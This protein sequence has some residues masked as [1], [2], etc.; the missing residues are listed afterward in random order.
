[1]LFEELAR[2][3]VSV[4]SEMLGGRTINIMD[5]RGII[6]ASS[7]PERVG[8]FHKGALEAAQTGKA[9]LIRKDQV[10]MYT[11]AKEGCNMPLRVDG[12]VI[13]VVGIYGNPAEIRQLSRLLELY[14]AKC[15]QL[16]AMTQPH[17]AENLLRTQ[18]LLGILKLT[19][20]RL[21]SVTTLLTDQKI[22]LE[23]PV[24]LWLFSQRSGPFLP[25]Q[26]EKL[27]EKLLPAGF[28]DPSRDLW[29][30]VEDRLVVLR[31]ARPQP[32]APVARL[33]SGEDGYRIC[34]G[35]PVH[36]LRD[37]RGSYQQVL[38]LDASSEKPFNDL[39]DPATRCGYLL[40]RSATM[41]S[42]YLEALLRK[43]ESAV[44]T[45]DRDILLETAREYY[46]RSHSVTQAAEALFVHKN[47]LMYRLHRL[48]AA[49]ELEELEGF[50]QEYYIRLLL[51][52]IKRRQP[53]QPGNKVQATP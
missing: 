37:I 11:G 46:S 33:V 12:T 32:E 17:M 13:G 34:V 2:D 36:S 16:E 53:T 51:E 15:Y 48:V 35:D 30:V 5:T 29:G 14:A 8:T 50:Q 43:L 39:Q 4:T 49:L 6:I 23:L 38:V 22:Q 19:D 9:V 42:E 24:T 28:L 10:S 25:Q 18:C 26:L 1:M 52:H 41:E 40:G 44:S 27:L 20:A 21:E 45:Q 31:S 3:L 7:D 47:T